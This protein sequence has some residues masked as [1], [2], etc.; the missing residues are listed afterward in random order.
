MGAEQVNMIHPAPHKRWVGSLGKGQ[1][2]CTDKNHHNAE[3]QGCRLRLPSHPSAGNSSLCNLGNSLFVG[4]CCRCHL[5]SLLLHTPITAC[6]HLSSSSC[7]PVP[8]PF[9]LSSGRMDHGAVRTRREQR[10]L[11]ES[12]SRQRGAQHLS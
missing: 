5:C 1:W 7:V 6:P 4:L 2:G 11:V 8:A 10:G 12:Q 3:T 9:Q